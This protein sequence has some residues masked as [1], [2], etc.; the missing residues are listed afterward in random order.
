[1]LTKVKIG[2]IRRFKDNA[3]YSYIQECFLVVSYC[4]PYDMKQ[5][6]D[7]NFYD[8]VNIYVN[9]HVT[10]CWRIEFLENAS[11]LLDGSGQS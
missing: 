6:C 7:A 1:M 8:Y 5:T 11:F 10:R 2:Q 9:G 3:G 4:D